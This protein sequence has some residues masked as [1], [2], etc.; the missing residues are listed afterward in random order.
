[1]DWGLR[2]LGLGNGCHRPGHE[3]DLTAKIFWFRVGYD[4]HTEPIPKLEV[5]GRRLDHSKLII[6]SGWTRERANFVTH[7][8]T[9]VCF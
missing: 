9:V 6:D 3:Q 8:L 1:M 4:Y 2:T 7:L 5:T